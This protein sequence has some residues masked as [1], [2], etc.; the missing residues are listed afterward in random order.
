[1][2]INSHSL[3]LNIIIMKIVYT[4]MIVL[5]IEHIFGVT[6][7]KLNL[8][9]KSSIWNYAGKELI[10][11]KYTS[12]V[13]L[14]SLYLYSITQNNNEKIVDNVYN[15]AMYVIKN[16]TYKYIFMLCIYGY[17]AIE[18]D[19]NTEKHLRTIVNA[20]TQMKNCLREIQNSSSLE[21]NNYIFDLANLHSIDDVMSK[22]RSIQHEIANKF[23]NTVA[24]S[25]KFKYF[26]RQS[27]KT[28][29]NNQKIMLN[30]IIGFPEF[31]EK[32]INVRDIIENK[33][34]NTVIT[35]LEDISQLINIEYIPVQK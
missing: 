4:L 31:H 3:T 34:D 12:L 2:K 15:V 25:N 8:L 1:M 14:K 23:E 30:I 21:L 18:F 24:E 7:D 13:P 5:V 22:L 29:E 35:K 27:S 9:V 20:F 6:Y 17:K 26:N 16:R 10:R 32:I 11:N 19:K 33:T 28:Y